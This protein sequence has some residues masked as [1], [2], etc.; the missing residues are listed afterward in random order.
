[1]PDEWD[2]FKS[3][4]AQGGDEF[5]Q[6]K[7][8]PA[9]SP[10]TPAPSGTHEMGFGERM[11]QTVVGMAKGLG[12]TALGLGEMADKVN[13][14]TY[15][16]PSQHKQQAEFNARLGKTL[17][18]TNPSQEAGYGA[19]QVMEFFAPTGTGEIKAAAGAGRL[20]KAG[21]AALRGGI[22]VGIKTAAQTGSVAEGAKAA[23]VGGAAGGVV[24]GAASPLAG[25]LKKWGVS[26]YARMVHPL[27]TKAKEVAVEHIPEVM[28]RGYGAAAA[29]ST[30]GLLAKFSGRAD[31]LGKQLE[32]EYAKLDATT[33]TNLKPI[34]DQ[35]GKWVEENAFTKAGTI[36]DPAI[37]EAGI[38]K[39]GDLQTALGPY[40]GTANPSTVW[41]VRQ[42]LDKYVFKN[43]L[44]AD[45]SVQA[46]NMVRNSAANSI[47]AELNSQH[48]TIAA[49]NNE[50]H[51]W[52]SMAELMDRNVTS[53]LGQVRFARN[54]GIMGRFLMGAAVGG[55]AAQERG[56]GM[57]E[58]AGA[59]TLMG[60]AFESPAW[61]SVS[62]V[63]KVKM[64]NL[65]AA[66]NGEAA[67]Q[68]A[69]RLTGVAMP[70]PSDD[71]PAQ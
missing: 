36:K 67:A 44:T 19:E 35:F 32:A 45:E 2:Q 30:E 26:Q 50:F 69:A 18:P 9:T 6:Y 42:A 24:E 23:V 66:G 22:D 60:L 15:L 29:G 61:R 10:T 46:G 63:S 38:K 17:Q 53:K 48:P 12:H 43:G 25:L 57:W 3:K 70:H 33:K 8:K 71:T 49:L 51:L 13:P 62:A 55:G 40:L 1:M 54:A 5:D 20:A 11:G 52:R 47:R 39:M 7:S 59:A 28:E 31:Q 21:Y 68:M 27:G 34:Y 65:I 14:S 58:T 4:P 16:F 37:L 64:A 56:A 41:E